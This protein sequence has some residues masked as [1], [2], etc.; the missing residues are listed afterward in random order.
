MKKKKKKKSFI[1]SYRP[2]KVD[3]LEQKGHFQIIVLQNHSLS[4]HKGNLKVCSRTWKN[5]QNSKVY[6]RNP[7][8]LILFWKVFLI[9]S[10]SLLFSTF[11]QIRWPHFN[12]F[13]SQS[14]S[15]HFSGT[16]SLSLSHEIEFWVY[17]VISFLSFEFS[18]AIVFFGFEFWVS[19]SLFVWLLRK[20][21]KIEFCISQFK[22]EIPVLKGEIVLPTKCKSIASLSFRFCFC[23]ILYC[24]LRVVLV[25]IEMHILYLLIY[26]PYQK[27]L[28]KTSNVV[29]DKLKKGLGLD[30]E[31]W[32][33]K[34]SFF[35]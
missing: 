30:I 12:G 5:S 2:S 6:S 18:L 25:L 26:L 1:N 33:S 9:L 22:M 4:K 28:I 17:L 3:I 14:V 24:W 7:S 34:C 31:I 27:K 10:F 16:L 20:C 19:L 23:A 29:W 21:W 8:P 32:V 15:S 13:D 11:S 35:K